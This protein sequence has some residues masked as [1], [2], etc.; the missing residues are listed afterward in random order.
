MATDIRHYAESNHED[1]LLLWQYRQSSH[2]LALVTAFL[3]VIQS[4]R[5][6]SWTLL[7]SLEIDV[8]MNDYR[9]PWTI[10]DAAVRENIFQLLE[11]K[12]LVDPWPLLE[13]KGNIATADGW[14]LDRIGERLGLPRSYAVSEEGTA[15]LLVFNNNTGHSLPTG[16]KW[17]W[18]PSGTTIG[19]AAVHF[20]GPTIERQYS[21]V[22]D[23]QYRNLLSAQALRNRTGRSIVDIE[24]IGGEIFDDGVWVEETGPASFNLHIIADSN[25]FVD[26]LQNERLLPRPAGVRMEQIW[27][28]PD[29]LGVW[30][31]QAV[32]T[33]QLRLWKLN[34]TNLS[35]MDGYYAGQNLPAGLRDPTAA[36]GY[37]GYLYVVDRNDA[38]LWLI[39][40]VDADSVTRPYGSLGAISVSL[41]DGSLFRPDGSRVHLVYP[42]GMTL[43]DGDLYVLDGD[44]GHRRLFR[45]TSLQQGA[46]TAVELGQIPNVYNSVNQPL[47]SLAALNG[48]L[49][50]GFSGTNIGRGFVGGLMCKIDPH[51]VTRTTGGYGTL[52]ISATGE[53]PGLLGMCAEPGRDDALLVSTDGTNAGLWRINPDNFADTS[54]DYGQIGTWAAATAG[55]PIRS[56]V[57]I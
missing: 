12:G 23:R 30:G 6:D 28:H 37:N 13:S 18:S 29:A 55:V 27:H 42:S 57:F 4:G 1:Y 24:A 9:D 48:D 44:R 36:A 21:A 41:P 8:P 5:M 38:E 10:V 16:R 25:E 53:G 52:S 56:L 43:L 3:N 31:L 2:F 17:Q 46:V 15:P 49:F 47:R 26:V 34:L 7:E 39:N 54:G 40:P 51:D 20:S 45:L 32:A 14:W 22:T 19:N 35:D 33:D 50:V 11:S